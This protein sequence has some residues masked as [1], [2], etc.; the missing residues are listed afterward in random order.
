MQ[1]E[2]AHGARLASEAAEKFGRRG[3]GRV[4]GLADVW[5]RVRA[6]DHGEEER[7]QEVMAVPGRRRCVLADEPRRATHACGNSGEEERGIRSCVSMCVCVCLC[8]PV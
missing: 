2:R 6:R 3:E 7:E 4:K 1:P 8:V 5:P